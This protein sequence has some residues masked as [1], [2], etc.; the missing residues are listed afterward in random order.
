M[1]AIGI[2]LGLGAASALYEDKKAITQK[3]PKQPYASAG[4]RLGWDKQEF[5]SITHEYGS[6]M[7]VPKENCTLPNGVKVITYGNNAKQFDRQPKRPS[8]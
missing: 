3:K 8:L 1:E 6:Y 5:R 2:L 7:G 4:S